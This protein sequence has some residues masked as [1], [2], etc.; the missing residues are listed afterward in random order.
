MK[1]LTKKWIKE[2][3]KKLDEDIDDIWNPKEQMAIWPNEGL[4]LRY[5]ERLYWAQRLKE[6]K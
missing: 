6:K 2:K 5:N 3:I 4:D 1:K